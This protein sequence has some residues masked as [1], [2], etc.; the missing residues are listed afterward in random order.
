MLSGI[1]FPLGSLLG[2]LGLS[3]LISW[4]AD[5]Q[6]VSSLTWRCLLR[7]IS[8]CYYRPL[9]GVFQFIVVSAALV[10]CLASFNSAASRTPFS[11]VRPRT[12]GGLVLLSVGSF[13]R[14]RW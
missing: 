12:A 6:R 13:V 5:V 1:A 2:T 4:T 10:C 3:V 8:L 11:A 14:D 9:I 7:W